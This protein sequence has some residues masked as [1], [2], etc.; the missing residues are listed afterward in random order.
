MPVDTVLG[1][2][3]HPEGKGGAR[4]LPVFEMRQTTAKVAWKKAFGHDLFL[5]FILGRIT[6]PQPTFFI[7][8]CMLNFPG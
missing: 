6:G 8:I 7:F 4:R 2:A 1:Y 5:V 3:I